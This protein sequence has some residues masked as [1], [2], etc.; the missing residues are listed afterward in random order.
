MKNNMNILIFSSVLMIT[1]FFTSCCKTVTCE[2]GFA[3]ISFVGF[4]ASEV[5]TF[6][7]RRYTKNTGF[8]VKVDSAVYKQGNIW[9]DF[10]RDTIFAKPNEPVSSGMFFI[11]TGYDYEVVLPSTGMVSRITEVAEQNY[12]QQFCGFAKPVCATV[13]STVKVNDVLYDGTAVIIK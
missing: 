13:I 12:E 4:S 10:K 5:E 2:P 7:L 1:G 9:Y 8:S 6:Y 11:T 3:T